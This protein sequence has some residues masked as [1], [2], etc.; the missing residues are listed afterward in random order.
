MKFRGLWIAFSLSLIA[1]S[2]FL[3]FHKGDEKFGIDF[4]GGLELTV[5]FKEPVDISIVRQKVESTGL[6]GAVVQSFAGNNDFS[7]RGAVQKSGEEIERVKATL[8]EIPNNSFEVLKQDFVGPIIG[9]QI[10][11]DAFIAT[12]LG[13]LGILIYVAARFDLVFAGGG[14]AALIH[15]PI[16]ATG[17]TILA[18]YEI[19]AATLAA[20]LTIVGFSINDTIVIFDRVRE[21]MTKAI[22]TG[23]AG[24]KEKLGEFSLSEILD[25]SLNQTLSRTLLTNL[26][27]LFV[28]FTLWAFGGGAVSELGFTLMIGVIV[29]TYSTVFV[30]CPFVLAFHR[31]QVAAE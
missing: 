19:N 11:K 26:T 23:S 21:N 7:I 22:K 16:I 3:W 15:D 20:V 24:K 4:R 31:K 12:L 1:A 17:A 8:G 29:G 27:V 6:P 25:L 18:G 13:F 14:I 10:R 28:C 5:R 9:E 2:I 30:A